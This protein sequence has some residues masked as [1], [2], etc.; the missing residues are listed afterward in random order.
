MNTITV[1]RNVDMIVDN[2]TLNHTN[3]FDTD[4]DLLQ[5]QIQCNLSIWG[6]Y[7]GATGGLLEYKK[8]QYTMII[9]KFCPDKKPMVM[10][11]KELPG[12]KV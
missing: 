8:T 3:T 5:A 9:Q 10:K 6:E 1:R 7:S 12:N 4:A 2:A 11:E